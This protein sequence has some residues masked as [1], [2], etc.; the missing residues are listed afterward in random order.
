MPY[1]EF[2]KALKDKKVEGVVFEPPSGSEAYAIVDGKSVRMGEGWPTD[3]GNSWS[4]PTWVVRILEEEGVP[5][6]FNFDLAMGT[7]KSSGGGKMTKA[8][9]RY[10]EAQAAKAAGTYAT[11]TYMPSKAPVSAL[12][13]SNNGK[14]FTA[15]P[16]MYGGADMAMDSTNYDWAG[17][18]IR[19]L[20]KP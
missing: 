16:K 12:S 11:N 5:Y 13:S 1:G 17:N 19:G 14:L 6:K 9:Q 8:E 15:Q 7:S 3:L 20:K 18:G 10:K 2:L 4:S